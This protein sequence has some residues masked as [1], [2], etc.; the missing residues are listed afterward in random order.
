VQSQ[1]KHNQEIKE[2]KDLA[3]GKE[4]MGVFF[5]SNAILEQRKHGDFIVGGCTY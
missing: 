5:Q 4:S 3:A 1:S 2:E